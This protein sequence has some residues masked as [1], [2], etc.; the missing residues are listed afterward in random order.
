MSHSFNTQQGYESRKHQDFAL[1]AFNGEHDS[2]LSSQLD[3]K[4][5][6]PTGTMRYGNK[7]NYESEMKVKARRSERAKGSEDL[8]QK[9]DAIIAG[10]DIQLEELLIN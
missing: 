3:Q 7:R 5:F 6:L 1:K 4:G 2:A 9:L 8:R 10:E